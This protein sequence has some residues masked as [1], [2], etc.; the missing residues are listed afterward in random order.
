MKSTSTDYTE[1]MNKESAFRTVPA[2]D[3]TGKMVGMKSE[4]KWCPISCKVYMLLLHTEIKSTE[5]LSSTYFPQ[6]F[7][8]LRVLLLVSKEWSHVHKVI[9]RTWTTDYMYKNLYSKH[10]CSSQKNLAP[11]W[12]PIKGRGNESTEYNHTVEH[13]SKW[14]KWIT[15]THSN[16][17][18]R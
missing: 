3:R 16:T 11:T 15:M 5:D 1:G 12:M 9:S 14:S 7:L 10:V 18:D 2:L 4:N 17:H 8:Q 13:Y 6:M